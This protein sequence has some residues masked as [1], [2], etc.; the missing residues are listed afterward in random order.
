M[1]LFRNLFSNISNSF[2][3][4]VINPISNRVTRLFTTGEET[5]TPRPSSGFAGRFQTGELRQGIREGIERGTSNFVR[6]VRNFLG[7]PTAAE[8]IPQTSSR[9]SRIVEDGER[10][11][12]SRAP[13]PEPIIIEYD[14]PLNIRAEYIDRNTSEGELNRLGFSELPPG[15]MVV[16]RL[17][18]A[19]FIQ[20]VDANGNERFLNAMNFKSDDLSNP[21]P[22]ILPREET[23]QNYRDPD[24]E[25]ERQASFLSRGGFYRF[26]R[27]HNT[28]DTN[29]LNPGGSGGYFPLLVRE[30]VPFSLIMLSIYKKSELEA[31]NENT[32]N[33]NCLIQ[34]LENN[35]FVDKDKLDTLKTKIYGVHSE[36]KNNCFSIVCKTLEVNLGVR[37][38]YPNQEK[39]KGKKYWKYYPRT[40]KEGKENL[41]Y[42][43]TVYICL[44]YNHF[45][46]YIKDMGQGI[47][48]K[49]IQECL[50]K[51]PPELANAEIPFKRRKPMDSFDVVL[52]TLRRQSLYF[53]DFDSCLFKIVGMKD[54]PEDII[55]RK[56]IL[57]VENDCRETLEF[58]EHEREYS[59][60]IHADIETT[61]KGKLKAY[62]VCVIA[63]DSDTSTYF[64][65]KKCAYDFL[66]YL[67][68]F[69]KPL[70]KFCNLGFDIKFIT[71]HLSKITNILE[72]GNKR[73]YQLTG[74]FQQTKSYSQKIVFVDQ[75]QQIPIPRRDY[76]KYFNL[77]GGKIENF[78]YH[79]YTE[80]S[81][82]MDYL[83]PHEDLI[84]KLEE[85]FPPQYWGKILVYGKEKPVIYHMR[86]AIDYCMQDIRTQMAGWEIMRER[87]IQQSGLDINNY[88]TMP[89]YAKAYFH[90]E[91][92]YEGV[93]QITGVTQLFINQCVIGG[94]TMASLVNKDKYGS[95]IINDDSCGGYDLTDE[96]IRNLNGD[97]KWEFHVDRKY[98]NITLVKYIPYPEPEPQQPQ[99]NMEVER[100][101]DKIYVLIEG[102][103][104]V[105]WDANS[106]YPSA[107]E[108]MPGFPIG[109]PRNLTIEEIESK[110]FIQTVDDYYVLIKITRVGKKLNLPLMKKNVDGRLRW[111]NDMVGEEIKISKT[112]LEE[113]IK[114][115]DIDFEVIMGI[116]F[117]QG[118][119]PKLKE[120]IRKLYEDRKKFKKEKNPSEFLTK[121]IMNSA[122]GKNNQKALPTKT[123][124][125]SKKDWSITKIYSLHGSTLN[126]IASVEDKWKIKTTTGLYEHWNY[127]QCGAT[128]LDWSKRIM[129]RVMVGLDDHILYTDTDSLIVEKEAAYKFIEENPNIIG[130]GLGQFKY[131]FHIGGTNRRIEEL[132]IVALK[133]YCYKE[134]NDEGDEYVKTVMKGVPQDS[135][136]IVAKQK[137]NGNYIDLYKTILQR[138]GGK[139]GVMFDL[140]NGKSKI[141][142]DFNFGDDILNLEEYFVRI[143]ST[144]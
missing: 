97:Y 68:R 115:H 80:E 40:K 33:K 44:I 113:I 125:L 135:L 91:G 78:P 53:T 11:S 106:L 55:Y 92:A 96:T 20:H 101:G 18:N 50:W 47:Y 59:D 13:E 100:R 107:M 4:R 93:Y 35:P 37:K 6:G 119:N 63:E 54:T 23:D 17:N 10:P 31:S 45:F 75:L 109:K 134:K 8:R 62:L 5:T 21:L 25:R 3:E 16:P 121:L 126:T 60:I 42:K 79:L 108:E 105:V 83:Q 110:S 88:L 133:I 72:N 89:A 143:T 52:E 94:R 120:I 49:Y 137:F 64:K 22:L 141:K 99:L 124:Y 73:T 136:D 34:S 28:S 71:P 69:D 129:N 46:P 138:E 7:Y 84:P 56:R 58:K 51:Y 139:K 140:T 111:T 116:A 86:Y 2:R 12:T 61:I 103:E 118:F 48:N 132:I 112:L 130:G 43:N 98:N 24:M 66:V 85:L 26:V 122:Y 14:T 19:N 82:Q 29:V 127:A 114:Y 144:N 128:I 104:Y 123:M 90:K 74:Y 39:G 81:T 41:L 77:E 15:A 57:D 76:K 9:A 142:M 131:E 36:A 38:F 117:Y 32:L 95:Y 67:R 102:K 1:S 87:S 30:E 70:V 27:I 65:G